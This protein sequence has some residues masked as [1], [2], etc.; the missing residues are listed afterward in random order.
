M[1]AF[2]NPQNTLSSPLEL[3][4][5]SCRIEGGGYAT[6]EMGTTGKIFRY[7]LRLLFSDTCVETVETL[8]SA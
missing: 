4:L 7:G 2:F 3:K 8:L 5:Q 1:K 6:G